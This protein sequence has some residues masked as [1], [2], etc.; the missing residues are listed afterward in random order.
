LN[1]IRAFL[2]LPEIQHPTSH[3]YLYRGRR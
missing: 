3:R 2:E 1:V